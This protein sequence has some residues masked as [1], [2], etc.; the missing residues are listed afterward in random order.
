MVCWFVFEWL[1]LDSPYKRPGITSPFS[2]LF[3]SS[4]A[5]HGHL[6]FL[7][8]LTFS[9]C[10][11]QAYRTDS[12]QEE[13]PPLD[14]PVGSQGHSPASLGACRQRETHPW[15]PSSPAVILSRLL[16]GARK[17]EAER[18]SASSAPRVW[19]QSFST[20]GNFRRW[21]SLS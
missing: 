9:I 14:H 13:S 18:L 17:G 11:H 2:C 7:S 3:C 1:S 6:L 20:E 8:R 15:I 5:S 16:S 10:F 12:S 4:E 21:Q 19:W